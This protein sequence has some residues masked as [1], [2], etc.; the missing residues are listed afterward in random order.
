MPFAEDAFDLVAVRVA[1]HHFTSP[2]KFVQETARVLKPGGH[3]LLIDGSVPEDDPETEEWLHR[4]EKWRD[5]S[6]GRFLSR[7]TWE[8][9]ARRAGLKVLRS[10]L[11]PRKQPDLEWYFD[12]AATPAENRARV[13]E[14]VQ[15]ASEHVRRAL[16]LA[17]EEGKIVWWWQVLTMLASK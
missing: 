1:P 16:Q 5:P 12:T 4:V 6:H 10:Q 11:D 9:L 2:K 8:D 3:F 13:L 7:K 15:T 17:T 14:A